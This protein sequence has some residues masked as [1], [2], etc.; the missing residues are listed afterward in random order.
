M[1]A[2][3]SLASSELSSPARLAIS[4]SNRS[5]ASC[6]H[7]RTLDETQVWESTHT[8]RGLALLEWFLEAALTSRSRACCVQR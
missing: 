5:F 8:T 3:D 4:A 6:D 2:A 7:T 1:R